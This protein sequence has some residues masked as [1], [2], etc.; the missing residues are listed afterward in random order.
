M[1]VRKEYTEIFS[2]SH[3]VIQSESKTRIQGH[4]RGKLNAKLLTSN[5]ISLCSNKRGYASINYNAVVY[6]MESI[7]G[8]EHGFIFLQNPCKILC[9]GI[10][11]GSR[12]F[13]QTSTKLQTK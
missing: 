5:K 3:T 10:L 1:F 2:Q 8:S 12:C 11:V 7:M 9:S 6:K 13:L 4:F